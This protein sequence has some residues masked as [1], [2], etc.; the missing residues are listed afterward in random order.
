MRYYCMYFRHLSVQ[1]LCQRVII[2]QLGLQRGVLC[3]AA[4]V[5]GSE[6]V[7]RAWAWTRGNVVGMTSTLDRGK[8]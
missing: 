2:A 1:G 6:A 7:Q 3:V 4:E 5:S 8:F